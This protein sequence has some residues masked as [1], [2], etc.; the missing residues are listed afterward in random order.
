MGLVPLTTGWSCQLP[1]RALM[2]KFCL[3]LSTLA[4]LSWGWAAP[5][6]YTATLGPQEK[7]EWRYLKSPQI[8]V[9]YSDAQQGKTW[10][11]YLDAQGSK[12][13]VR[14]VE[15]SPA[16]FDLEIRR[17]GEPLP[18]PI[19]H[20]EAGRVLDLELERQEDW[21]QVKAPN[22]W[23]LRLYSPEEP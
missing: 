11:A 23:Q 1:N 21:L 18:Y 4:T 8:Q 2:R 10:R 15:G 3:V 5:N 16:H 20:F 12:W 9:R 17:K 6:F 7:V 22:H 19:L 14:E 13:V